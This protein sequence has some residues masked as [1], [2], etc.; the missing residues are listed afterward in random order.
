MKQWEKILKNPG[1]SHIVSTVPPSQLPSVAVL[2]CVGVAAGEI[3]DG[4]AL[5]SGGTIVGGGW[6]MGAHVGGGFDHTS[7]STPPT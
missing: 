2:G 6:A 1:E 7:P 5:P 4:A 3:V